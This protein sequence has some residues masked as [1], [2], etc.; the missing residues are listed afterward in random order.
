MMQKRREPRFFIPLRYLPHTAPLS[1]G[2][3]PSLSLVS[4]AANTVS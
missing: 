2:C 4:S 3:E 1:F